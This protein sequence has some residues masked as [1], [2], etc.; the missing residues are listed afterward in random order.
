MREGQGAERAERIAKERVRS[1]ERIDV[2][3]AVARL[4]PPHRLN[5]AGDLEGQLVKLKFSLVGG[6]AA[7]EYEPAEITVGAHIIKTVVMHTKVSQVRCHSL[8]R[9]ATAHL[10][11]RFVAGRI[12]L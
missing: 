7:F 4:T 11:K 10:E 12:E 3:I 8:E 2:A 5:G 9:V 6:N 1:V